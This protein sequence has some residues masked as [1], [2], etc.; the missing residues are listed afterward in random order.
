MKSKFTLTILICL[1]LNIRTQSQTFTKIT[2]GPI[3]KD[4]STSFGSSWID[5]DQDDD[6]DLFV[7]NVYFENDRLYINNGNG[8][9]N[10][11]TTL[12]LVND[13]KYSYNSTWGDYDNDGFEDVFIA[14]GDWNGS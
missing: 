11:I 10:Q 4:S 7:S 6:L 9:F 1:I 2:S 13:A 8:T 12:N 3:V 5:I 14:N